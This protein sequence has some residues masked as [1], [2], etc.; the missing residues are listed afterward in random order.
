MY[1]WTKEHLI[2]FGVFISSFKSKISFPEKLE[3]L[4][5]FIFFS[6]HLWYNKG[7]QE[8]PYGVSPS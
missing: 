4:V 3:F 1:I 6:R 5:N 8:E 2:L 7:Q